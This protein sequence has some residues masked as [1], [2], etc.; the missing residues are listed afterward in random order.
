[1]VTSFAEIERLCRVRPGT[2][3]KLS[4]FDTGWQGG[5]ALRDLGR[6]E[7]KERA[8]EF[9]AQNISDLAKAQDRLWAN[10]V[11]SVLLVLQAM[12]VYHVAAFRSF[13]S[14]GI[15]IAGGWS[16]VFLVLLAV[17]FFSK[18]ADHIMK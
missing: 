10:D 4:T 17:I 7:R 14:Q 3:V 2:R 18:S 9:L 6:D 12:D 11:Y 8:R 15:R 5:G 13:V 1:M 16:I